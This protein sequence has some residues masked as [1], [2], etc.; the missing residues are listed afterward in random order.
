RP[1]VHAPDQTKGNISELPVF[2]NATHRPKALGHRIEDIEGRLSVVEQ[3]VSALLEHDSAS[4]E[5]F[6]KCETMVTK[7]SAQLDALAQEAKDRRAQLDA[8][9]QEA[10]DARMAIDSVEDF[11][12]EVQFPPPEGVENSH[13]REFRL[14]HKGFSIKQW[15]RMPIDVRSDLERWW[16]AR[17]IGSMW[18]V[19][20]ISLSLSALGFGIY[21]MIIAVDS[22]L[23]Y[24]IWSFAFSALVVL[25][26]ISFF[27][28]VDDSVRRRRLA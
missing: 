21:L 18:L 25:F 9:V 11:E 8:L 7:V 12:V 2:P 16:R 6:A 20:C 24:H 17:Y 22:S 4:V 3:D 23:I 15:H 10:K 19:A 27:A 26:T 5:T 28:F 14:T 13:E 1:E